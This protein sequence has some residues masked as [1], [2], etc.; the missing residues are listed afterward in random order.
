MLTALASLLR[1]WREL[2]LLLAIA[3]LVWLGYSW[4]DLSAERE[5][6]QRQV[7]QAQA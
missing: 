6:A 7:A 3:A 5:Q 4:R 1:Y 2:L